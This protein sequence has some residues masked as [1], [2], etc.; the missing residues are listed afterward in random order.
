M[1][2]GGCAAGVVT[3]ASPGA[4][5][6]PESVVVING[7]DGRRVDADELLRR[8]AA[9]DFVLLGELHDNATHH[10]LRGQ[11]ITAFGASR[12][13]IV[14]EQFA[15]TS[16]PLA[17]PAEGESREAW[18]DR[19]GFDR[20][21]W[22]WPLHQPVV[23][24]AITNGASLWGSGVSREALRSVVRDGETAAPA[25]LRSLMENAPLDSA[26]Q[27]VLDLELV[28]G[29][30]GQLPAN[31]VPGMRAAQIVRDASMANA[32][33]NARQDAPAWLIAGNGHV[34]RDIAVPRLLRVMDP[35]LSV[36]AVG[37]LERTPSGAEPSPDA[38]AVFDLVVVTPHNERPD[39]CAGFQIR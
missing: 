37:F 14:F 22:N 25:R 3:T 21:A 34:R 31:M 33:R 11:L 39:P 27:V 8:L 6:L 13:A 10:A 32:L 17:L 36:V 24:A 28:A 29:H 19:S 4:L 26:A 1:L 15:E 5:R 2:V 20:Q 30:C 35:G 7:S 9:A 23:D 18:L 38:R 12:P 16:A